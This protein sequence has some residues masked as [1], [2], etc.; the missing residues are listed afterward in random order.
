MT[1]AP[2]P[3]VTTHTLT[4]YRHEIR[5]KVFTDGGRGM[6]HAPDGYELC[7][8][9]LSVDMDKLARALA[10]KV[11]K[12]KTGR[13]VIAFGSCVAKVTK[14]NRVNKQDA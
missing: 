6:H 2:A 1:K 10:A 3:N 5:K 9:T 4:G 12:N 11:V 7:D 13:A 8:I 14:R